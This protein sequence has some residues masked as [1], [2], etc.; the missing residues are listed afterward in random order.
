MRLGAD[1]DALVRTAGVL[2]DAGGRLDATVGEVGGAIA[3][4]RWTGADADRF[5]REWHDTVRREVAGVSRSLRAAAAD[6]ARQVAEQERASGAAGVAAV[7]GPASA[8]VSAGAAAMALRGA[9]TAGHGASTGPDRVR[10]VTFGATAGMGAT[11][12]FTERIRI[13]HLPDGRARVTSEVGGGAAAGVGASRRVAGAVGGRDLAFGAGAEGTLGGGVRAGRTW[14]VAGDEVDDLLVQLAAEHADVRFGD[15]MRRLDRF[16][17]AIGRAAD[18]VG[19]GGVW[20]RVTYEPPVPER[21]ELGLVGLA[22]LDLSADLGSG[23]GALDGVASDGVASEGGLSLGALAA[24]GGASVASVAFHPSTGATSVRIEGDGAATALIG[25]RGGSV[26]G[27]AAATV[28]FDRDRSPVRVEV[29]RTVTTD[30]RVTTERWTRP[31][32]RGDGD[33]VAGTWTR[34]TEHYSV[35]GSGDLDLGFGLGSLEVTYEDLRRE[36]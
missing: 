23:A 5:R 21:V 29:E 9:T 36:R 31:V 3:A 2:T 17:P 10:I 14:V 35:V 32:G 16:L 18:A 25:D 12:W 6:V 4:V 22:D 24:V 26:D 27:T 30:E 28:T 13:E 11:G 1:T 15:Q 19:L 8:V 34:H 33:G 7:G 20:D